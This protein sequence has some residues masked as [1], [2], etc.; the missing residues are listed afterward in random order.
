LPTGLSSHGGTCDF[1]TNTCLAKCAAINYINVIGIDFKKSVLNY[2]TE[3]SVG[4]I[5]KRIREETEALYWFASGDC[6]IRLQDKFSEIVLRLSAHG[7]NQNGFT[8]NKKFWNNTRDATNIALTIENPKENDGKGFLM[9]V[10]NYETG[11]VQVYFDR[12]LA[13]ECWGDCRYRCDKCISEKKGC[14]KYNQSPD[15]EAD[16]SAQVS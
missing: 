10:P 6:P 11:A 4:E 9:A 7:V 13:L 5:V 16:K 3:K 1:A 15:R 12:R 14:F 8:R 2:L